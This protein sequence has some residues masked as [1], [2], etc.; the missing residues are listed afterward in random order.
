MSHF[1]SNTNLSPVVIT[2]IGMVS[3]IGA[4]LQTV[5]ANL[6]NSRPNI[7][8]IS[9]FDPTL[10]KLENCAVAE[11]PAEAINLVSEYLQNLGI[12]HRSQNRF[13]YLSLYAALKS[14]D[15][16]EIGAN[17]TPESSHIGLVMGSTMPGL[18]ELGRSIE[19]MQK[20]RKPKVADNLYMRNSV[21][22]Q[23]IA[24]NLKIS[25]P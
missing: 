3:P 20:G 18:Q 6:M 16:S 19:R 24:R 11:I 15:D 25:G 5:W 4:D 23:E 21:V 13:R 7:S 1:S 8:R 22:L 9:Q 14:K 12:R 2:G 10:F 17:R